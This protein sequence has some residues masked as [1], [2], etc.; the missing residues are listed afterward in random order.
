M[1]HAT[2]ALRTALSGA[3]AKLGR[4]IAR[5]LPGAAEGKPKAVHRTRVASRRLRELLAVLEATDTVKTRRLE[6][7]ARRL[8]RALGPAREV[9]VSIAMLD[10]MTE[11]GRLPADP[12]LAERLGRERD[13]RRAAMRRKLARLDPDLLRSHADTLAAAIAGTPD[14]DTWRRAVALRGIRRARATAAAVAAC[15]T[16]YTPDQLHALRIAIKKLRYTLEVA[17][18]TPGASLDGAIE[19]LRAAQRELGRLHDAQVLLASVQAAP[20]NRTTAPLRETLI[21]A[22]ERDCRERHAR[23]LPRLPGI[24]ACA[25]SLPAELARTVRG[26]RAPAARIPAR[27]AD[28]KRVDRSV[29]DPVRA[30]R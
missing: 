2:T 3:I 17:R 15:G 12:A 30:A 25:R 16:L 23:L 9:D 1:G 21:H 22:L 19:R 28:R 26:A 8:T 4:E 6:R 27:T 29:A 20:A 10:R 18:W 14:D 5:R 13:R 24:D 7:E 11:Q